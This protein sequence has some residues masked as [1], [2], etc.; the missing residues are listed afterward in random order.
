MDPLPGSDELAARHDDLPVLTEAQL[1]VALG[2]F[3]HAIE[4]LRPLRDSESAR[5]LLAGAYLQAGRVDDAVR[6]L[7]DAADHFDRPEHKV[8]AIEILA[9]REHRYAEAAVLADRTLGQLPSGSPDRA[10]LHEVGVAAAHGP[11]TGG[12]WRRGRVPGSTTAG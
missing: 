12:P 8:R 9:V 2:H 6:E 7:E 4:L 3:G 1:D 11:A 10:L 5:R